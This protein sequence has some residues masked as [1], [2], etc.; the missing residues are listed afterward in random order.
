MSQANGH[1]AASPQTAQRFE[2][3]APR[4]EKT[5]QEGNPSL[6]TKV[7]GEVTAK[8]AGSQRHSEKQSLDYA[9]RTGLA[10]GL[11]GCAV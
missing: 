7:Q 4:G 11:A 9:V 6:L 3:D 1:V 5:R 8:R 10:G 2:M